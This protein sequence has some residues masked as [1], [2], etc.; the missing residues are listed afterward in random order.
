VGALDARF[1]PDDQ[2]AGKELLESDPHSALTTYIA[3][4]AEVGG[5][6]AQPELRAKALSLIETLPPAR[7][8]VLRAVFGQFKA[9]ER[10]EPLK[11]VRQAYAEAPDDPFVTAIYVKM[12]LYAPGA[13]STRPSPSS[14]GSRSAAAA[15]A[16]GR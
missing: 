7:Q 1:F 11:L 9:S 15:P 5:L 16:S 2:A 10:G 14:T 3:Y 8:K 13:R 4:N 12:A 6:D